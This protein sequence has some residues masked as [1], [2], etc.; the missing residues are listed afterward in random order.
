MN[1]L[2]MRVGQL[3]S[4]IGSTF[5]LLAL[6]VVTAAGIWLLVRHFRRKHLRQDVG[7]V[8]TQ[9]IAQYRATNHDSAH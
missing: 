7:T 3:S 9:W 1:E 8:S 4:A 5:T 2:T 6:L